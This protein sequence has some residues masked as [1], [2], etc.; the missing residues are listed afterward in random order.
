MDEVPIN[1]GSVSF[2]SN[3]VSGAQ[4]SV[5]LFCEPERAGAQRAAQEFRENP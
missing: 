3:E 5:F 4:N 2:Q 1:D